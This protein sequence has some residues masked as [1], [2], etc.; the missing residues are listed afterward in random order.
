MSKQNTEGEPFGI[1]QHPFCR[2][3]RKKLKVGPFGGKQIS[4][5]RRNV[6]KKLKEM[7]K[8]D[9]DKGTL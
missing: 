9:V 8:M 6:E 3:T 4:K 2:K 5:K 1:F 7:L